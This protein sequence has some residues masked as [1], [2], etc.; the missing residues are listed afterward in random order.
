ML[1]QIKTKKLVKLIKLGKIKL[2]LLVLKNYKI[3]YSSKYILTCLFFEIYILQNLC[4]LI[5]N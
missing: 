2:I 5:I 1:N 3:M 4:N